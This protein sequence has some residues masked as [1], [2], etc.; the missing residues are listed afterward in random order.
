MNK[1]TY[2]FFDKIIYLLGLSI[3]LSNLKFFSINESSIQP[4]H[5]LTL[6]LVYSVLVF[7]FRVKNLISYFLFLIFP[8]FGILNIISFQDFLMTYL[9]YVFLISLLFLVLPKIHTIKTNI[10]IKSIDLFLKLFYITAIFGIVQFII[11]NIFNLNNF[12]NFFGIFQHH[13]HYNNLLHGILRSTSIYIEPSVFAWITLVN[14]GIHYYSKIKFFKHP[15]VFEFICI[16]SIFVSQSASGFIGLLFLVIIKKVILDKNVIYFV[17]FIL[18]SILITVY[19]QSLVAFLRLNSIFI[20]NTSGYNR[21]VIP[22]ETTID[23]LSKYPFF[24]IGIGQ[25]GLSNPNLTYSGT[26]HNSIFGIIITFGFSS[27]IVYL[28]M[29]L[30]AIKILKKDSSTIILIFIL[31]FILFTTGSFLSLELVYILLLFY[32]SFLI[33]KDKFVKTIN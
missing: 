13:Y 5:F 17:I 30:N 6:F 1:Y 32:I 9:I 26:I 23:V 21:I 4:I 28:Y 19:F 8:V 11:L 22:I 2:S 33:N 29:I 3:I 16:V 27:I 10:L 14:L 12:Y 20:E 31:I 25:L 18:A 15:A 24:G 7:K